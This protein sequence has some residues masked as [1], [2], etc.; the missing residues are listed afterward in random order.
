MITKEEAEGILQDRLADNLIISTSWETEDDYVFE[1][2]LM[3]E[4]GG[5]LSLFGAN[6]VRIDKK[7]GEV[8]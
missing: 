5:L 1:L 4:D 7:T 2:A 8:E 3:G 6:T